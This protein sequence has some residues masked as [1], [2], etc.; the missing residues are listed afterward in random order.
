MKARVLKAELMAKLGINNKEFI[1]ES[2]N[3]DPLNLAFNLMLGN[4]LSLKNEY[5]NLATDYAD[6]GFYDKAIGVLNMCG[7]TLSEYY[8]GYIC[9]KSGNIKG[10]KEHYQKGES[11]SSDYVFPNKVE[12][13]IILENAVS[14]LGKAPMANYYL[15][16]FYYDKK[17][18]NKAIL[19]W[20]KCA[21]LKPDFAL[22]HRNLS[23]A[24]F[25]KQKD[26][27]KAK[28]AIEKAFSLEGDNSRLLLEQDQ[29]YAK[30]GVS[31]KERLEVLENNRKL[32]DGRDVLFLSYVT[33][34]NKN[35]EYEKALNLI[36]NHIFHPWEGGE[37]KV[38]GEYK[39]ALF[40]IA[41][42]EIEN[43]NYQKAITLCEKTIVYPDNL[44]EGKLPNVPDNRAHYLI[45]I[46]YKNLGEND[47]A[48]KYFTLATA[49]SS[50]PEP[51]RYYNDQPS[52]YIYYQGLAYFELGKIDLAKK[53]FNQLI[54]FGKKHIFDK[55]EYDYFAVSMP[56]LE[57]YE[58]DIQMRN[59]DYCNYMQFLGEKGMKEIE[60]YYAKVFNKKI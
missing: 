53:S 32:L 22:A 38:S 12:E 23:I 31:D 30:A 34:L 3:I 35:G 26:I 16:N 44:G 46:C 58:D 49:G 4:N 24:Y 28:E 1:I 19:N 59:N 42:K 50:V 7:G 9:F 57:V 47:L 8:K 25:N 17:E 36:E 39:T 33:L 40:A 20:E 2:Y 56:E 52:D 21:S 43:K 10:A 54:A 41:E 5:L 51:V 60:K 48:N 18:Y 14:L 29:F 27:E 13:M 45:G 6:Y 37:G 55:V 11:L 15:G